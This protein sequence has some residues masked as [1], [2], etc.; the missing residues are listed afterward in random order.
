MNDPFGVLSKES[1]LGKLVLVGD[2]HCIHELPA[3]YSVVKV[4][5]GSLSE[6]IRKLS[7]NPEIT[8]EFGSGLLWEV[9]PNLLRVSGKSVLDL[10]CGAGR[11]AVWLAKNGWQV[12]AVDRL[13]ANIEIGRRLQSLYCPESDIEWLVSAIEAFP[14]DRKFDL[15]LLHYCWDEN[16]F[17][18]AKKL[19]RTLSIAAHSELSYRCFGHPRPAKVCH[20]DALNSA[21]VSYRWLKDRHE[22]SAIL[23]QD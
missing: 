2:P 22:I 10:G 9:H 14:L 13:F 5:D 20:P 16:N 18:K 3:P 7:R 15:V 19:G 17:R 21:V 11:E 1:R 23:A 4:H 12:T 6:P 8:T